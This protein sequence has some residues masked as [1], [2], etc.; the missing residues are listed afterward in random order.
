MSTPTSE[1]ASPGWSER[2]RYWMLALALTLVGANGSVVVATATGLFVAQNGARKV[3][4]LGLVTMAVLTLATFGYT[5]LAGRTARVQRSVGLCLTGIGGVALLRLA[6]V[7]AP[8]PATYA[9]YVFVY[10]IHIFLQVEVWELVSDAFDVRAA[11]RY[12][13]Q[14]NGIYAVGSLIGGLVPLVARWVGGAANVFAGGTLFMAAAALLFLLCSR[15]IASA[16]TA[17]APAAGSAASADRVD[18]RTALLSPINVAVSMVAVGFTLAGAVSNYQFLA[19]A[20]RSFTGDQLSSLVGIVRGSIALLKSVLSL[21]AMGPVLSTVGLRGALA[22]T[23][24]SG[25]LLGAGVLLWPGLAS[26]V[27][28]RVINNSFEGAMQKSGFKLAFGALPADQRRVLSTVNSGAIMPASEAA[29]SILVLLLQSRL[30]VGPLSWLVIGAGAIGLLGAWLT[31]RAY[32]AALADGLKKR[33]LE[34]LAPELGADVIDG[35]RGSRKQLL[36]ALRSV[37]GDEVLAALAL[38]TPLASQEV[39]EPVVEL[40]AHPSPIIRAQAL[41]FLRRACARAAREDIAALLQHE[42]DEWV[43][44]EG[45]AAL[46]EVSPP[47]DERVAE[48]V[49]RW[50][51]DPL[52]PPGL[53]GEAVVVLLGRANLGDI[54]LGA[55]ALLELTTDERPG[56][57]MAAARALGQLSRG[58]VPREL[59]ALTSDPNVSVRR[60]ALRAVAGFHSVPVALELGQLARDPA[61]VSAVGSALARS[62]V[63]LECAAKI[64]A[65]GAGPA[66]AVG[67]ALAERGDAQAVTVLSRLLLEL[68]L[69]ARRVAARRLE[70]MRGRGVAPAADEAL[71]ALRQATRRAA[72]LV[73]TC[74]G[75]KRLASAGRVEVALLEPL[76]D[77]LLL[78]LEDTCAVLLHVLMVAAPDP[79]AIDRARRSLGGGVR[80]QAQ[81]LEV[82]ENETPDGQG[83]WLAA[84]MEEPAG[85]SIELLLTLP[86]VDDALGDP[87]SAVRALGSVYLEALLLVRGGISAANMEASDMISVVEK[88]IFLR[89]V[90]IFAALRGD[91]LMVVA[92]ATVA[93]SYAD[94]E[95]IF[96]R[97]DQGDELFIVRHGSVTVSIGERTV[98]ALGERETLGE[99]ALLDG[100]PRT[101]DA[102]ARGQCTLLA[103][104]RASFEEIL[105]GFPE[106]TRNIL[107][108]IVSRLRAELEP[109]LDAHLLVLEQRLAEARDPVARFDLLL[110]RAAVLDRGGRTE[111]L[112]ATLDELTT[113]AAGLPGA[114]PRAQ[115]LSAQ[116][117]RALRRGELTEAQEQAVRLRESAAAAVSPAVRA[118][119]HLRLATLLVASGQDADAAPLLGQAHSEAVAAGLPAIVSDACAGQAVLALRGFRLVEALGLAR[120][121]EQAARQA[122]EPDL[123]SR[124]LLGQGAVLAALGDADDASA[125]LHEALVLARRAGAR[126]V[127]VAA[128]AELARSQLLQGDVTAA[129]FKARDA[130]HLAEALREPAAEARAQLALW[131]VQAARSVPRVELLAVAERSLGAARQ[132]GDPYLLVEA[133]SAVAAAQLADAPELAASTAQKGLERVES[134]GAELPVEL[135]GT[136]AA[137]LDRL[138]RTAE[139]TALRDRLVAAVL[140]RAE[141][142]PDA[143]QRTTFLDRIVA[144]RQL[145]RAAGAAAQL[146]VRNLGVQLTGDSVAPAA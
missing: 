106:I 103:L 107:R 89:A 86:G 44:R 48:L 74:V 28:L 142:I 116:V 71:A 51:A 8:S 18:A 40:L 146:E 145:L 129:L 39:L 100:A 15:H 36:A 95:V 56:H 108:V 131:R 140:A 24:L 73:A 85:T 143:A 93:R 42:R 81:A 55:R 43:C 99:M 52:T 91:E 17:S 3:P 105:D 25:A 37:Q 12:L 115:V 31:R 80:L 137:A 60:A 67:L 90:P 16:E 69:H 114:D 63:L 135:C 134:L 121:S 26:V 132:S 23:P 49:Q 64:V 123:E 122:S 6:M 82:L 62:P 119:A 94:G 133:I 50:L 13:P 4:V 5:A 92:A 88:V 34:P 96:R 109:S 112:Q 76:Q 22:L 33:S 138:G 38:L 7:T 19:I 32:V 127:E 97:G 61:L 58:S 46:M 47:G 41:G 111:G 59:M 21:F 66:S 104:P 79:A 53:R 65:L 14:L 57:R 101:A 35:D 77:E 84:V 126:R 11:K 117:R 87:L 130:E 10:I 124:A 75:L 113:L 70:L 110:E 72:Q 125:R 2:R 98:A 68:P 102:V 45:L 29:G 9:A 128:L 78:L 27:A 20:A 141:R 118:E 136:L 30:G 144:H 139:A 54:L 120:E 1:A 83:R